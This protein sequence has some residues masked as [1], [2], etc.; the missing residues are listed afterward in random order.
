MIERMRATRASAGPAIVAGLSLLASCAPAVEQAPRSIAGVRADAAAAP[1]PADDPPPQYVVG[2]PVRA[3][4]LTVLPLGD[5][6]AGIIL[7]GVRFVV[8]G[9][10]VRVSSDVADGQQLQSAWRV[11]ARLGGGF[12]FHA[13]GALYASDAFDGLLRPVVSLPA[14]V[15]D[16]WFGPRAILVRAESGERWMIEPATGKRL[17]MSPPGLLQIAALDDGRAIALV[18]GGQILVSTDAGAHWVAGGSPVRSPAKRVFLTRAPTT[19]EESLWVETQGTAAMGLLA[20]GRLAAYDAAPSVD[21]VPPLRPKQPAWHEEEPPLRRATRTGAPARD[22]GA[23]VVSAG[24]LVHV[25]LVSGA[26]EVLAA[27]KLPPDASCVA[28]RT[29]E[30]V[31]FTCGRASGSAFVVA[32]ALEGAP[33]VE[34]TFPERGRFVVSDDGGILR[35]GPCDKAAPGAHE[36]ACVR[37]P[38]GGWQQLE[39]DGVV[40]A[41]GSTPTFDVVRWIP[42]ADG[43]AVAVVGAIGGVANAWGIADARTGDVHAWPVDALTPLMRAALQ[44]ADESRLGGVDPARLA[45][46]GWTVTAQGTLRG[47]A[48]LG[49]GVGAVDVGIDGSLQTSPFTFE[50]IASAGPTALARTRE[51]RIWQTLD[52]GATWAEVA[53][54]PAAR[55]GGWIDSHACS[56]VGCD[57]GQWYRI[58]WT[59]TAPTPQVPPVSAPPAPRVEQS[60][61]PSLACRV[62]GDGRRAAL[63]SDEHS[64]EDLGLGASK[65]R[66]ADPKGLTDFLRLPFARRIAGAVRDTDAADATA[67]RAIVHGPTTQP[68]D[69]RLVVTGFDHD[70]MAL[71]RQVQFVPA[72]DPAGPVRRSSLAMRDL[73]V[74]ARAASAGNV[75]HD[76]PVPSGVVPVTPFEGAAPDD[77]AVQIADGGVALLRAGRTGR[78]RVAYEAGRDEEWRIV[79]AAGLEGD[80]AAWLEE[81]SAGHAR[82]LR[83]GAGAV[84]AVAFELDAPPTPD[85]YPANVDALAVGPHGELGVLR[86]PSGSEP[87][88]ADDPALV[89]V[90]GGAPAALAPWSTLTSADDPAC[91]ADTAGWRVTIQ[92]I[93][94]WVR[95]TGGGELR[96]T[97]DAFMLARVR[98]SAARACLEAVELRAQDFSANPSGQSAPS[99]TPL[100]QPVESWVVARFTGAPAAAR[101]VVVAGAEFRQPLECKLGAP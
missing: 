30:D 54:P 16:V 49:N 78:S 46:R 69:D 65:L 11:P 22:G 81:D 48:S 17:P 8:R 62:A 26:V 37:V 67:A 45:D 33:V 80:G 100:D 44:S 90:P 92:T 64:P 12:L 42:R 53:A 59:P 25:D 97:E 96:G 24:D 55:P 5:D 6:A 47:W 29:Q 70:A 83:L 34:Q 93:A 1:A 79:S 89:L 23:L 50:R 10:R 72:F 9:S 15:A 52:R 86:A 98:W 36:V 27:G 2:D 95:L 101:L 40:E 4:A 99:A 14:D 51:G 75:W 74:A 91:R 57:L 85:L 18:E 66:V 3:N 32:H 56:S 39:L 71:V 21:A 13:K 28:T 76:D 35:T 31:V 94:P 20:G 82:V 61:V 60:P 38:G 84:P 7:E 63:A 19:R 88:S 77:L 87:P 73:V 58:G 43:G 68:G 41:G